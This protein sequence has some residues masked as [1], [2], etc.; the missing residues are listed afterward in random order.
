MTEYHRETLNRLQ[1]KIA[2][3]STDYRDFRA[4]GSLLFKLGRHHDCKAFLEKARD[5]SSHNLERAKACIDLGWAEF[6][7]G[8]V[9]NARQRANEVQNYLP[10]EIDSSEVFALRG[11]AQNIVVHCE[12]VC[13]REKGEWLLESDQS[14][15]AASL[16]LHYLGKVC[17]DGPPFEDK[18]AV[19]YDAALIHSLL[20]NAKECLASAEQ[21]LQLSTDEYERISSMALMIQTLRTQ[22]RL[23]EAQVKVDQAVELAKQWPALSPKLL[24]ERGLI[25][26]LENQSLDAQRSFA[27]ALVILDSHSPNTAQP[28][29]PFYNAQRVELYFNL[30]AACFETGDIHGACEALRSALLDLPA[31]DPYYSMCKAW[32]GRCLESSGTSEEAIACFSEVLTLRTDHETKLTALEGLARVLCAA[33]K[34]AKAI[35]LFEEILGL[36]EE[37]D[38]SWSN[39][40]LW[41]G[42][43]YEGLGD[44][45]T[46]QLAYEAV[47][48]SKQSNDIEIRKATVGLQRIRDLSSQRFH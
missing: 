20:G 15:A 28:L 39:A 13:E 31:T 24:L 32:L 8:D 4:M 33:R 3:G 25:Q 19:F 5:L 35:K 7:T 34:Y 6:C 45:R 37:T 36:A 43:C 41:L 23:S 48:S 1:V 38:P 46:A 18:A 9:S 47:I 42:Y 11:G 44:W 21:C 27:Q 12:W 29:K 22:G 14:K 16:A 30:G 26:R 10:G 40:Q 17:R 2:D